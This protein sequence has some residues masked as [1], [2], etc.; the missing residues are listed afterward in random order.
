MKKDL[1]I[2]KFKELD[3][4]ANQVLDKIKQEDRLDNFY[5]DENNT[6]ITIYLNKENIYDPYSNKQIL[7]NE[8]FTYIENMYQ[9]ADKRKKL[10]IY[11]VFPKEIDSEEKEYIISL[12]KVAY[13][14]DFKDNRTK[15]KRYFLFSLIL[16][17]IGALLLTLFILLTHFEVN[18]IVSEIISIFAWVF[19]WESC[20][21]FVFSRNEIKH[22][23]KKYMRLYN[24]IYKEKPLE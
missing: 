3:K 4:I 11:L 23:C 18:Y 21:L 9:L 8:I 12:F 2:I 14:L 5:E 19:V 1:N 6:Y 16:L 17:G 15:L 24:A 7:N 10:H 22:K 20:D 13:A